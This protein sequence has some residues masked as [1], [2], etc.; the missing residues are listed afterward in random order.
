MNGPR[1]VAEIYDYTD[2]AGNLLFQSVRYDPK[3]FK[4]RKP[5]GNGGW[6]YEGVFTHGTRPVL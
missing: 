2:E 1:K 3:D 4:Q 6:V 5:D